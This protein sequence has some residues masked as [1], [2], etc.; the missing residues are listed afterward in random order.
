[1]DRRRGGLQ[2]WASN[3][4]DVRRLGCE[5]VLLTYV[6]YNTVNYAQTM[7]EWMG[8]EVNNQRG[9]MRESPYQ[10]RHVHLCH[11]INDVLQIKGPKVVLA[12]MPTLEAGFGT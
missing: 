12:T 11:D 10:L 1:M 9:P 2:H 6:S 4:K 5:L 7:T 8:D 3:T